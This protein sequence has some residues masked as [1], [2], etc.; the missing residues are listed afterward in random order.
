MTIPRAIISFLAGDVTLLWYGHTIDFLLTSIDCQGT[1]KMSMSGETVL[2]GIG[3]LALG[4]ARSTSVVALGALSI[5]GKLHNHAQDRQLDGALPNATILP[6]EGPTSRVLSRAL[7]RLAND[8][9]STQQATDDSWYA[10]CPIA[11]CFKLVSAL[12]LDTLLYLV[13]WCLII[14]PRLVLGVWCLVS[15]CVVLCCVALCRPK[16]CCLALCSYAL[17]CRAP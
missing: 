1:A 4:D 10:A 16:L 17:C 12:L 2:S 13:F 3:T 5:V 14:S 8:A 6:S 15:C 11:A 9:T 7:L